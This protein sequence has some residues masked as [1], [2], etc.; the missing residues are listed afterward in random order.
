MSEERAPEENLAD[1][2]RSL[3]KNLLEALRSAWEAPE[4]KRLSEELESN[5]NELSVT[6]RQ[7][8]DAFRESPTGQRLKD[9]LEDL[10][11]RVRSGAAESKV[12]EELLTALRAANQ[13]L[14]KVAQRWSSAGEPPAESQT[15]PGVDNPPTEGGA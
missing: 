9:D 12:R 11:D 14:S 3:G 13:E 4:R 15:P 6:L 2:F 5:L 7:E 10:G 1:E 8:M